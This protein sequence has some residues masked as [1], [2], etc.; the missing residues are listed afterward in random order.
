[1]KLTKKQI[2]TVTTYIYLLLVVSNH[3]E[4][5]SIF[6]NP[7]LLIVRPLTF[8]LGSIGWFLYFF[9]SSANKKNNVR[10]SIG[11]VFV[12]LMLTMYT[13]SI[14]FNS[15]SLNS[16]A[17]LGFYFVSYGFLP[18]FVYLLRNTKDFKQL[19]INAWINVGIFTI[20]SQYLQY[21]VLYE[22]G[23][24]FGGV[25]PVY[26]EGKIIAAR[27]G[28][29]FWDVNH[30][31]AYLVS[32]FYILVYKISTVSIS[33]KR[34]LY[35]VPLLAISIYLTGSR[36]ALLG[37]LVSAVIFGLQ[38]LILSRIKGKTINLKY[39]KLLKLLPYVLLVVGGL[40]TYVQ[41]DT[42]REIFHSRNRSLWAHK[43][44]LDKGLET[45]NNNPFFGI[46]IYNFKNEFK[47]DPDADIY[48]FVDPINI[49][50]GLPL[51]S[52][53]I[54][55]IAE[56]GYISFFIFLGFIITLNIMYVYNSK[57]DYKNLFFIASINSYLIAGIFYSYRSE[58]FVI[59]LMFIIALATIQQKVSVSD[60]YKE[61]KLHQKNILV[62]LSIVTLLT[63]LLLINLP[64]RVSEVLM[65]YTE[66]TDIF[67]EIY[68]SIINISRY[69]LGSLS[70]SGRL[71]SIVL[72]AIS[73][74]SL[75][76]F[77][78][79]KFYY[80][81]SFILA[82]LIMSC[83]SIFLPVVQINKLHIFVAIAFTIL[84][85]FQKNRTE[86]IQFF[87][88]NLVYHLIIFSFLPLIMFFSNY[89]TLNYIEDEDLQVLLNAISS[90]GQ[91]YTANIFVELENID[92]NTL[93]FYCDRILS[94]EN[95][96]DYITENCQINTNKNEKN[97]ILITT[98]NTDAVNN[99]LAIKNLI[100]EDIE[101][102]ETIIAGDYFMHIYYGKDE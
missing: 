38:Y 62:A 70:I 88:K 52:I 2:L 17:L 48:R 10:T 96:N 30:Y 90:K 50:E 83:L 84:G 1:M 91:F 47:N 7:N 54:E 68:F 57:N 41:Q 53:W 78:N 39:Q 9:K 55:L 32:L 37:G 44:L 12:L 72:Y 86:K 40:L 28:S 97:T 27:F 74:Y 76:L 80:K 71:I 5:F 31:A 36:S 79:K 92:P 23:Y 69:I 75:L 20:I 18:L 59:W 45:G 67:N 95:S 56:S 21:V 16:Y 98:S 73:V 65:F 102:T 94:P 61:I 85:I 42:L 3:K 11:Y 4:L 29:I 24:E 25:W 93:R 81:E 6:D 26:A 100:L 14:V 33:R 34:Y 82:A 49:S 63:P 101:K 46:G 64:L 13:L 51:H 8:I 58:F 99:P 60:I 15:V 66:P 89:R 22:F 19:F 77:L 35:L 43:F 87:N